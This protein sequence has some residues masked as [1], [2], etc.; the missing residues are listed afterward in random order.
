[1]RGRMG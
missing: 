1:M